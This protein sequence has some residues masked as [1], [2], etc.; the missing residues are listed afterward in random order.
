VK[1]LFGADGSLARARTPR[2]D[3]VAGGANGGPPSGAAP[4]GSVATSVAELT[5]SHPETLVAAAF[6]VGVTLAIL[7]RRLGR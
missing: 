7:T 2:A 4:S 6:A 5:Q 1:P 3:E